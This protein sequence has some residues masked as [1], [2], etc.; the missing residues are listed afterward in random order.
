M[1]MLCCELLSSSF[2]SSE[3]RINTPTPASQAGMSAVSPPRTVLV[4]FCGIP[5]AGK[6]TTARMLARVA[7]SHLCAHLPHAKTVRVW[8]ISFDAVLGAM[9]AAEGASNTFAPERWHASRGRILTAVREYC[10]TRGGA[11]AARA[12]RHDERVSEAR[13]HHVLVQ[14]CAAGERCDVAVVRRPPVVCDRILVDA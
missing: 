14:R 7:P 1:M 13:R 3:L 11:D 4:L 2:Y 5:A 6:S 10:T 9:A 12:L 8:H